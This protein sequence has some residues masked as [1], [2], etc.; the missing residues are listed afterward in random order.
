MRKSVYGVLA[1]LLLAGLV[2]PCALAQETTAGLQGTVKDSSGAVVV[3]AGVEVSGT[4]LIGTKKVETDQE[5]RAGKRIGHRW[6]TLR[7]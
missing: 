2:L 7:F 5:V 6:I 1:L 3:R 4:A